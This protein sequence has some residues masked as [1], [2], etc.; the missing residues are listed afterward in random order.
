MGG[1]GTETRTGAFT[2][3]SLGRD[4]SVTAEAVSVPTAGLGWPVLRMTKSRRNGMREATRA[5]ERGVECCRW[6]EQHVQSL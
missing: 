2:E 6:V 1:G 3:P 5:G 4:I